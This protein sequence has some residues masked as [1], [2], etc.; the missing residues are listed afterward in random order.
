MRK[1]IL[2]ILGSLGLAGLV[3]LAWWAN[4]SGRYINLPGLALVLLGT[5]GAAVLAHSAGKVSAMLK[6]LPANLKDQPLADAD[7][8]EQFI[9]VAEWHRLG[10]MQIAEQ[11][12]KRLNDP[13]LR[14][15]AE[16]VIGRTPETELQ[17][18][19]AWKIGAQRERDQDDIK[20]VLAMAGFAP[21]LGMLGTL[22]GLIEMMY[23]LDASQMGHIGAAMGFA[24]IST[25]YGLI[26]ANLV[27]K[28]IAVRL[29]DRA[30]ERLAWRHVQAETVRLLYERG[31]PSLIRD[32]WRAFLERSSGQP[33]P[34][35]LTLAPSKSA[36]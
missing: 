23:A 7:E 31:H 4:P 11:A 5:L 6:R 12:A 30:R 14:S 22:V 24:L 26:A 3:L 28:P 8:L 35:A 29:E 33:A 10:R 16:M 36:P 27:L 32:Y 9:R 1:F 34:D 19:L 15:G 21:A 13:L 20:I 2:P 18:M 25:V 17:R